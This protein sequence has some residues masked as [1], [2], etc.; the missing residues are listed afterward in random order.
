MSDTQSRP[1]KATDAQTDKTTDI[2]DYADGVIRTRGTH[3]PE[4]VHGEAAVTV[5]AWPSKPVDTCVKVSLKYPNGTNSTLDL[6]PEQA[7]DLADQLVTAAEA[8][9]GENDGN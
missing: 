5:T 9:E 4:H 6:S 3:A 8:M 2:P 1:E 7:R